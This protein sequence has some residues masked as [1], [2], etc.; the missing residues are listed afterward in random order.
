MAKA[1]AKKQK[2]KQSRSPHKWSAPLDSKQ[3]HCIRCGLRRKAVTRKADI[4]G[5][6]KTAN[7]KV[8]DTMISADKGKTWTRIG[9]YV[10]PMPPCARAAE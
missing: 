2:Q 6:H 1:K 7:G 10:A 5:A 3:S 8:I 4:R 9:Q